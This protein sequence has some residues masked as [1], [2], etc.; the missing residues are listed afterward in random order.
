MAKPASALCNMR[1]RYCFYADVADIREVKY[2]GIM[3]L[4]TLEQIVKRVFEEA[5]E[6][7]AIGFQGGE[8]TLAGL[9]FF[10]SLIEFERKYNKKNIKVQHMLQ[11]NGLLIDEE[12]ASFFAKNRFL[13]GLSIDGEK[14]VHDAMRPDSFGKGTHNRCLQAARIM[15]KA[16][17][18][19]NILTVV[20]RQLAA[21]PDNAYNF[22]KRQGFRYLQFIPCM[23]GLEETHGA[24][25]YSL[26]AKSYGKFLCRIF[27]LWHQDYIKGNYISVRAFDNYIQ[28]LAGHPPENCAMNGS[29]SVN[30]L[31][32]ADGCVYPCDFYAVD[33]FLLGNVMDDS[34]AEMCQSEAAKTFQQPS[35]QLAAECGECD[36]RT[37]CRG[38]CR[39]DC[40]PLQDN[41]RILN[42]YCESYKMFFG[43]ALP[44]MISIANQITPYRRPD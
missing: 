35:I 37:I 19:F 43:H 36:Y 18:D 34:F 12:W 41:R 23:D 16:G 30:A 26:D 20:T 33:K 27:D 31:I 8:P 9:D 25:P 11:T 44:R 32:E 1:C 42:H 2:R 40:E 21:H 13:I 7:C 22:Y 4:D 6:Y 5:D 15:N 10:H 38:G 24:N 39:R 17:A 28:M 3:S 14:A 29:C